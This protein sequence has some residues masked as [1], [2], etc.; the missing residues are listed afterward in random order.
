[1]ADGGRKVRYE[2]MFPWEIAAAMAEAPLCYLPLGTLEWHGEHA[3]V[4]LDAL[5][6][7]AVCILAAE[8]SGGLVVPPLYWS[9]DWREDLPDGDYLTGGIEHGERYH[10]PGSMFWLRPETFHELLLDI[11]EAMR[12]RG[13]RAIVVLSG[14]WSIAHNIAAIRETGEAFLRAHPKMGWLLLTD[15][16]VASDLHY[17]VEHAAG[18]ETSLLMAIRPDLVAL[19]KVFETTRSLRHYY[20]EEPEHLRRRGETPHKYIGVN[21]AVA[22]ASNDPER[23]TVERGQVLLETIVERVAARARALLMEVLSSESS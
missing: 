23:A 12:R 2:E 16:E 7:H 14:H 22:D 15:Q 18:S 6:A 11:Y 19:D 20:A 8:R 5:K 10:V 17:P 3:A 9:A 21:P 1:M 4:G 13:F